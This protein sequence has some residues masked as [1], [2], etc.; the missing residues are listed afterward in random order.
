MIR[1]LI[2][3]IR[4]LLEIHSVHFIG[5]TDKL[6][7]PLSKEDEVKYV[8]LSMEGDIKAKS[9]AS[10]KSLR[11]YIKLPSGSVSSNSFVQNCS[12]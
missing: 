11:V 5:S 1:K 2:N 6:P 4:S 10:F 12:K 3:F 8:S 7:E 9:N